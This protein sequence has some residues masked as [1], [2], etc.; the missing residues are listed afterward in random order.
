M[1]RFISIPAKEKTQIITRY[2]KIRFIPFLSRYYLHLALFELAHDFVSKLTS[3][4]PQ[5]QI[6]IYF[7]NSYKLSLHKQ[8]VLLSKIRKQ[9]PKYE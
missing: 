9:F 1:N 4:K 8:S 7:C 3:S 6:E 5:F 2:D